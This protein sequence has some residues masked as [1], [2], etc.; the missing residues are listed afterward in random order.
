MQTKSTKNNKNTKSKTSMK[1][2]K[3]QKQ[4][5][6]K[7]KLSNIIFLKQTFRPNAILKKKFRMPFGNR[8]PSACCKFTLYPFSTKSGYFVR[9]QNII[10][11]KWFSIMEIVAW[12]ILRCSCVRLASRS[13]SNLFVSSLM[14]IAESAISSPLSSMKG[15]C[16]FFERKRILWST[17]CKWEKIKRKNIS[18]VISEL[19]SKGII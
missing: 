7:Q 16:P 18:F 14:M 3:K 10:H 5:K 13:F 11:T 12:A 15:S 8:I 9:H 17:F 1:I 2:K 6:R 19:S 4:P